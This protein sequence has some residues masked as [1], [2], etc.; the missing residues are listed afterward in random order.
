MSEPDIIKFENEIVFRPGPANRQ[1]D[2]T[3]FEYVVAIDYADTLVDLEATDA[4]T[5]YPL[6]VSR[7]EYPLMSESLQ[8]S[9]YNSTDFIWF[10]IDVS[11]NFKHNE[12]EVRIEI[13][14]YHKRRREAFPKRL[15][16][17]DE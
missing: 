9:Q 12:E 8:N 2:K 16:L 6:K 4:A 14:E 11:E 17:L 7:A 10:Q 1:N 15:S 3:I 5:N 13:D